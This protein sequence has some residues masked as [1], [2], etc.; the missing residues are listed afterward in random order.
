MNVRTLKQKIK[1]RI[2][3][4]VPKKLMADWRM[5]KM[6][7]QSLSRT[8]I[9]RDE[10]TAVAVVI[11][12]YY[13]EAW[14]LLSH[15]LRVLDSI[16]YDLFITLPSQNLA[17]AETIKAS[18]PN[19]Y[20][21]EV[22][23]RG[24]DVLPFIMLLER[25]MREGYQ[26]ALKMHSKK[27]THR[28][29]GSEWLDDMTTNLLPKDVKVL[30]QLISVLSRS[31]TGVVGPAG[32]YVSLTVNFEANGMHMTRI[33]NKTHSKAISYDVLQKKRGEYGFFAGTMFWI[34]LDA[35]RPIVEQHLLPRHF[36][37]EAGQI[38][39]T[40]AHALERLFNIIPEINNRKMYEIDAR[41]VRR[42]SYDAGVVPD[43]SDVYK[44]PTA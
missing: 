43:W 37:G 38:D 13:T 30:E 42:V 31:D 11:H 33:V 24:R 18:F 16:P 12:L 44:G 21:I 14:P 26:Y 39:A 5:R 10:A 35:I 8:I 6:Y 19:A 1:N 7:E 32:Q 15:K 28:T 4:P 3:R 41:G 29:D 23:N 25:L 40:L 20:I 36:E 9:R 34:R 2:P 22:P 17:F 27:S